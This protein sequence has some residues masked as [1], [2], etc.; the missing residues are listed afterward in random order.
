VDGGG[1]RAGDWPPFEGRQEV[2]TGA[3]VPAKTGV[4][5]RTSRS[6]LMTVA[7]RRI[8]LKV[9]RL[10]FSSPPHHRVA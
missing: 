7:F 10:L 9:H 6:T 2:S 4:P 5:L 8:E 3:F 1:P